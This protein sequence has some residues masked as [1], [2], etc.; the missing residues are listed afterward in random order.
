MSEFFGIPNAT[1]DEAHAMGLEAFLTKHLSGE[2][3]ARFHQTYRERVRNFQSIA[4]AG[5]LRF[6]DRIEDDL[7]GAAEARALDL[8]A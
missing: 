5:G 4:E 7:L 8:V 2:S 3:I 1:M 6:V